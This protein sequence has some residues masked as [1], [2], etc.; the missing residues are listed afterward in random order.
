MINSGFVQRI[1]FKQRIK[2]LKTSKKAPQTERESHLQYINSGILPQAL[3]ISDSYS[4]A[5]SIETRHPF[6]DKRLIEFCLS[7]PPEQKLNKGWTRLVM[8]RAMANILPEQV[9][10]RKDK[11]DMSSS[12][13]H[14]LLKH[15]RQQLD[16][17]MKTHLQNRENYLNTAIV[18]EIYE[19]LISV[20]KVQPLESLVDLFFWQVAILVIWLNKFQLRK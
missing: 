17:V 8:R 16:Y 5:F 2:T 4:V 6:M 13:L 11:A 10:W 15:D 14:G 18:R 9:Q 3:K 1:G 12:F 7:L 19:E 20:D